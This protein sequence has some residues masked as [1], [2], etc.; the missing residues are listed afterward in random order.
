M[1]YGYLE[2]FISLLT[3]EQRGTLG[4]PLPGDKYWN[5]ENI[6]LLKYRYPSIN[7]LPY[8]SKL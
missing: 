5:R 7:I 2:K 8:L 4:F 1:Y 3:P 6:K